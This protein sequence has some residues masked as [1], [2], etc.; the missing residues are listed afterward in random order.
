MNAGPVN[1]HHLGVGGALVGIVSHI[2]V[3]PKATGGEMGMRWL[4]NVLKHEFILV[5]PS[6]I[7]LAFIEIVIRIIHS[8][9]RSVAGA[10]ATSVA[11]V[12]YHSD[13]NND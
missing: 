12:N 2:N 3:R 6:F 8:A 9:D 7:F 1:N 10:S 13:L 4:G 5:F 11:Q